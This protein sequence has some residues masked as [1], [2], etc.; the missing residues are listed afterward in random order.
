[1]TQKTIDIFD[2]P[3][4]DMCS[5][6]QCGWTGKL[7]DTILNNENTSP[8]YTCPVCINVKIN[9]FYYSKKQ[10][11]KLNEWLNINVPEYRGDPEGNVSCECNPHD[12]CS[13]CRQFYE[14]QPLKNIPF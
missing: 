7:S 10:L 8:V 3:N 12:V 14:D 2:I 5:C 13:A 11:I 1:M 9:K 6:S 4:R